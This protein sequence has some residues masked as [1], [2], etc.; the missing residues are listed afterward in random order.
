M[1][2]RLVR[3]VSNALYRHAPRQEVQ[4]EGAFRALKVA[5]LTDGFTTDCLAAEC[6]IRCLTRQNFRTVFQQ[7]RPDLVFVESAFHGFQGNWRYELAKQ[8]LW[9]RW[10][11]P[12][13]IFELLACAR[14]CHIPTVFWNKDDGAFFDAFIDVA[15]AFDYVFTTDENCLESY[16]KRLPESV[17]V[18]VLMMPYQPKFHFFDG[19]HFQHHALCFT[20]SYYR[21]ILSTR[22]AFMDMAFAACARAALPVHVFDRNHGRFSHRFEFRYPQQAMMTVHPSVS[23]QQTAALY[24]QFAFSLNVNSV[25]DSATMYSR[26]LLEILACGG[27]VVTNP[28]RAVARHFQDFCHVVHSP[29]EAENLFTRFRGGP[30]AEDLARAAAGAQYVRQH[31][32]WAQ[33]L[34]QVC[35]VVG[36]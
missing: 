35:A 21:K 5:V 29:E 17:P 20:G 28:G 23:H 14:D 1:I 7:W 30:T 18:H 32:T 24:K 33:R 16:R 19:F 31:H 34:E 9:L 27:V 12:T 3:G 36:I 15:K 10:T 8:P 4:P 6:Q 13:A 25:T 22:R 2:A 26:R 11:K